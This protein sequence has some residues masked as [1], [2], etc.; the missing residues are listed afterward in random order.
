[1]TQ[2]DLVIFDCDGVLIDSE[3]I[4]ARVEAA[5]LAR[6][7]IAMTAQD[8][9]DRFTGATAET[10]TAALEADIGRPLRADFHDRVQAHLRSAF[11]AELQPIEGIH[12]TLA[13]LDRPRCVASSSHLARLEE[14][15]RLTRLY[16]A[17]A[18]NIFSAEMVA[19]G[20]PAPDLFL[21][22]ARQMAAVPSRCLVIED[23]VRGV[24]AAVAA[25]MAVVGFTGASHCRP[26]HDRQL[27]QAGA[28]YV[29]A[30]MH[31]LTALLDDDASIHNDR[32]RGR[33]T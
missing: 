24:Q 13:A 2:L 1:M 15:L 4:A 27:R 18:P 21:H 9:L 25:G 32:K 8:I 10:M 23:S 31:E 17:F 30:T 6:I 7:G 33:G 22:A 3:L 20:K 16:D 14:T 11:Q 12:A 19:H 29:V 28:S 26:G 5:E